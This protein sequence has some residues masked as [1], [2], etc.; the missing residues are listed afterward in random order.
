MIIF[1]TND[2]NI[3]QKIWFFKK[4]VGHGWSKTVFQ[5][6]IYKL[7]MELLQVHM[8]NYHLKIH[9]HV[10]KYQMSHYYLCSKSKTYMKKWY[11]EY[12]IAVYFLSLF[13]DHTVFASGWDRWVCHHHQWPQLHLCHQVSLGFPVVMILFRSGNS[14]QVSQLDNWV[15]QL[16]GDKILLHFLCAQDYA[17]TIFLLFWLSSKHYP[18]T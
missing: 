1:W 6:I 2:H 11:F 12:F 15:L 16:D 9:F 3:E 18:R 7:A 14:C 17:R 13:N 5:L 10:V 8:G 4:I